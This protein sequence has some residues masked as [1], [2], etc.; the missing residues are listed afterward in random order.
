MSNN[1]V[2]NVFV[3]A[4]DFAFVALFRILPDSI[5]HCF[6]YRGVI[7][8]FHAREALDILRSGGQSIV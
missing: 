2:V 1:H 7:E 8:S 6:E 3:V 5:M 4:A